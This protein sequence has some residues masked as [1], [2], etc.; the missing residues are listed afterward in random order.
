VLGQEY[1][2]GFTDSFGKWNTGFYCP[3]VSQ[4]S[5]IV[6]CC[7]TQENMYCCTGLISSSPTIPTYMNKPSYVEM[8]T[9]IEISNDYQPTGT[10]TFP[11]SPLDIGRLFF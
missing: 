8:E 10:T 11:A 2:P 9:E 7:G 3:P 1:C 4:D 6:Y 5:P